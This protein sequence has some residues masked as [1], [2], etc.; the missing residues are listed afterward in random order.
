MDKSEAAVIERLAAD[1]KNRLQ[2]GSQSS[3]ADDAEV[4]GDMARVV[5]R[6]GSS[7]ATSDRSVRNQGDYFLQDGNESIIIGAQRR[8]DHKCVL[9]CLPATGLPHLHQARGARAPF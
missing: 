9:Q 8:I 4:R 3:N 7:P 2:L 1:T 5:S 6:K